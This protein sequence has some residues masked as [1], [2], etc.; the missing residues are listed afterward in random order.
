[1]RSGRL[2]KRRA[3]SAVAG[4][5]SFYLRPVDGEG[6][7]PVSLKV[8]EPKIIGSASLR[9]ESEYIL[10]E[11][12]EVTLGP[13]PFSRLT[14]DA[15]FRAVYIRERGGAVKKLPCGYQKIL[16]KGCVLYLAYDSM[17]GE[18]QY[19]YILT[20]HP[21]GTKNTTSGER[22]EIL[23]DSDA[24]C[25]ESRD[26][27]VISDSETEESEEA[28]DPIVSSWQTIETEDLNRLHVRDARYIAKTLGVNTTGFVEKSD[29]AKALGDLKVIGRAE[30][31]SRRKNAEEARIMEQENRLQ[32]IR[33]RE[34][35]DRQRHK[36]VQ[37]V[38][39]LA[40]NANLKTF[41]NRIGIDARAG[42]CNKANLKHAYRKAMMRYHPDKTTTKSDHERI[43]AEEITKWI[44]HAWKELK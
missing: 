11:H 36:A 23:S 9:T 29:F 38:K 20:E 13:S 43:L 15:A 21:S 1:M 18:P 7:L 34:R 31:L 28:D 22:V 14:V 37:T 10:K 5:K 19:G 40:K 35:L 42:P 33:R 27:I 6:L 8:G 16:D 3:S 32:V 44:T 2:R 24:H 25:Q 17:R 12:V 41:L 39:S 26:T 30:W 4:T